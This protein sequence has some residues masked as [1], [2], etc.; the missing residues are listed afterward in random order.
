MTSL[1][2][3]YE[4]GG[5]TTSLRQLYLGVGLF[6]AG[7][8]LVVAGILSA[9]TGLVTSMGYSLGDARLFGGVFGGVGV[10]L[11][12][13]GVMA[14][15]PASRNTRAAA[16]VGASIMGLGVAM[17]AHAY[18]CQWIGNTC[19]VELTDLTLPTAG[20]YFLGAAT[21]FWCLFVGV[22]NFKTRN[23]P[24]GTVT[25]EVTHKGE[26]K[27]VEVDK[28]RLGGL[29][30]M[31]FLGGT[32]DG[33]VETQTNAPGKGAGGSGGTSGTGRPSTA[34]DSGRSPRT[35]AGVGGTAA[36]A[37]DGGASDTDIS[38]PMD[39]A[40]TDTSTGVD[41]V[42]DTRSREWVSNREETSTERTSSD[43]RSRD[44]ST[45]NAA[46]RGAIGDSS[47]STGSTDRIDTTSTGTG[48]LPDPDYS[49]D[50]TTSETGP[51]ASEVE[52]YS[53]S[54]DS[55]SSSRRSRD[56]SDAGADDDED[57]EFIN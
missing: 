41:T 17:F 28:G 24:G 22:A 20:I 4:D 27:V 18:P 30:G 39:D 57:V 3:V 21:T 51:R 10:P 54:A 40:G 37:S 45:G 53:P 25:M 29:G 44:S 1:S 16:I 47:R 33:D 13:L 50:A 7:V 14:V 43:D 9:G 8:A 5:R 36:S 56:G 6:V 55:S 26:T 2:E 32:P 42:D 23:D 11:V 35:G 49:T 48:S 52:D 15:L 46:S 12:M 19:A 31:G 34:S 38:S